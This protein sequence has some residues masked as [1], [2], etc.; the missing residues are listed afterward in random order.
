MGHL[1]KNHMMFCSF[2]N[3][4]LEVNY[5]DNS[6]TLL[7]FGCSFFPNEQRRFATVTD[8]NAITPANNTIPFLYIIKS[9]N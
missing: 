2:S 5:S 9:E 4:K 1:Y 6:K 8:R 7:V 3:C